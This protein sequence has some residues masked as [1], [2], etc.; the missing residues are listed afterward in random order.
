MKCLECEN[1]QRNE[2]RDCNIGG[3][4]LHQYRPYQEKEGKDDNNDK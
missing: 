4:A 2:V 3:C 1:W